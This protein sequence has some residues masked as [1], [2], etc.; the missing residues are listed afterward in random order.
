MDEV[1]VNSDL[2]L[3]VLMPST[4]AGKEWMDIVY[5]TIE[6]R[7]ASDLIIYNDR[8]FRERLP[9]SAFLQNVVKGKVVYEKAG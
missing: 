7:V 9:T 5:D 3:F 8:E 6:R 4:R 1:D 2:D